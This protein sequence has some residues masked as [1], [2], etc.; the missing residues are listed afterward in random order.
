VFI[1]CHVLDFP[2]Q[3]IIDAFYLQICHED[4][5]LSLVQ[6]IVCPVHELCKIFLHTVVNNL[7]QSSAEAIKDDALVKSRHT[8]ENRCPGIL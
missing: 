3:I 2:V 6:E 7:R 5:S 1:L 4:P 8:G